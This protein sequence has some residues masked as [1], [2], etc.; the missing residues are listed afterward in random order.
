MKE[1]EL[2]KN[3]I[4]EEVHHLVR[5]VV[6]QALGKLQEINDR[7]TLLEQK[8]KELDAGYAFLLELIEY[9][10]EKGKIDSDLKSQRLN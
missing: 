10:I 5:N 4:K 8:I 2:I 1:E 9:N 7:V 3:E 6:T